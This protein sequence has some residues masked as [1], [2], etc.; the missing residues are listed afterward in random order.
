MRRS[1]SALS[2]LTRRSPSPRFLG[3]RFAGCCSKESGEE[4]VAQLH[5]HLQHNAGQEIC[6]I[7]THRSGGGGMGGQGRG[8]ASTDTQPRVAQ[9]LPI[10]PDLAIFVKPGGHGVA[11]CDIAQ[12]WS[13]APSWHRR[14][15]QLTSNASSPCG[16][17]VAVSRQLLHTAHGRVCCVASASRV[18]SV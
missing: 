6:E 2:T 17:L 18:S 10:S 8:A 12:H 15:D 7:P 13:H 1:R 16:T 4:R 3:Q 5:C 9:H 11:L 14:H